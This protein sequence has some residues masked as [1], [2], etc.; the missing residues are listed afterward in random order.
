M[1]MVSTSRDF[2]Y[3]KNVSTSKYIWLRLEISLKAKD[4]GIYNISCGGQT[5]LKELANLNPQ[6]KVARYEK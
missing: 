1:A 3:V 5:T 2:C 4:A 6:T